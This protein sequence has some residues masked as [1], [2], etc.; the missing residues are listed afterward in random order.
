MCL[1]R[2]KV[3]KNVKY[4]DSM[5]VNASLFHRSFMDQKFKTRMLKRGCLLQLLVS[6]TIIILLVKRLD[7]ET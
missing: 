2:L 4:E 6:Q 1:T 7:F 3:L 5:Q